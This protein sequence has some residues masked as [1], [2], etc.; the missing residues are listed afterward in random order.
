[1][2][3]A[4]ITTALWFDPVEGFQKPSNPEDWV[5]LHIADIA[6]IAVVAALLA[7]VNADKLVDKADSSYAAPRPT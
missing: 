4:G 2:V 7:D 3:E 5:I 1:M 6:Y